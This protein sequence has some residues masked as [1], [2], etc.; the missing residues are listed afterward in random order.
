[1]QVR[2]RVTGHMAPKPGT[3]AWLSVDD[4]MAYPRHDALVPLPP[5]SGT[6]MQRSIRREPG[7]GVL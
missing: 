3:V 1:M 4:V 2:V 6:H 5:E 7:E